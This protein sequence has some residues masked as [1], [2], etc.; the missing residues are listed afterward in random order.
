M[1]EIEHLKSGL[2]LST[3]IGCPLGCKY[4]TLRSLPAFDGEP[5]FIASPE[6]ITDRILA[7]NALFLDGATPLLINNRTD[8]F[9]PQVLPFT[10]K[11]LE[12][13]I[14]KNVKSPVV[15]ITKIIP[16]EDFSSISEKLNLVIMYS[17]SGLK[18]DFNYTCLNSLKR[19]KDAFRGGH[20]FHYCRP[21]IPGCNDNI[22]VIKST[23][24]Q[25]VNAGFEGTV[26]SGFRITRA[27]KDLVSGHLETEPVSNHK[28]L[29]DDIYTVISDIYRNHKSGYA[30][31]RHTSCAIDYAFGRRNRLGYFS[32]CGHCY[33]GCRNYSVCGSYV[34]TDS[35]Q[36]METVSDKLGKQLIYHENNGMIM[37]DGELNQE[38]IAFIRNAYG[39]NIHSEVET[40]SPSEVV[41][42]E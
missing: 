18:D 33:D 11:L 34:S 6:E 28:I 16:D 10:G 36:I 3:H 1:Y 22:E 15:L 42:S 17:Y 7:P 5:R 29:D 21:I 24:D 37:V 8:P 13:L 31:F 12:I 9:L 19:L 40:L 25:F 27:N 20:L 30:I 39:I 2:S 38:E 4:C 32:K 35:D 14:Q 41:L 26:V 23:I